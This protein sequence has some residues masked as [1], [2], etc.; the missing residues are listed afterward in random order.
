MAV[1]EGSRESHE[2]FIHRK[3]HLRRPYLVKRI[4]CLAAF[5]DIHPAATNGGGNSR[6]ALGIGNY[7]GD[8]PIR[9]ANDPANQCA[10]DFVPNQ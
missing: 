5:N 2:R 8:R 7:R 6:S 3:A 10:T 1:G 4:N 9:R